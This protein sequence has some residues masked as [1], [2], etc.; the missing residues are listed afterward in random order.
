MSTTI[1]DEPFPP[2]RDPDVRPDP[3]KLRGYWGDPADR[4]ARPLWDPEAVEATPAEPQAE[5]W[6][7]ATVP[8]VETREEGA[9]ARQDPPQTQ[10]RDPSRWKEP[11]H[12]V[13]A[14]ARSSVLVE[15]QDAGSP[16]DHL[17]A[18][19]LSLVGGLV[20]SGL[21]LTYLLRPGTHRGGPSLTWGLA[22]DSL[23]VVIAMVFLGGIFLIMGSLVGRL[24]PGA[25]AWS[26][27]V[28]WIPLAFLTFKVAAL[29]RPELAARIVDLPMVA[30]FAGRLP[31]ISRQLLSLG[32]LQIVLVAAAL[33]G[34]FWGATSGAG[35]SPASGASRAGENAEDASLKPE[36][37]AHPS[38]TDRVVAA[39]PSDK[40]PA[41]RPARVADADL[42]DERRPVGNRG[43]W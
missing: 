29:L 3:A 33:L 20:A 10:R 37:G 26:A 12:E 41:A 28:A 35:P 13:P 5:A 25:W 17:L 19:L 7:A 1:D 22:P 23:K 32:G 15:A 18:I 24:A 30:Q 2:E 40:A 6:P 4:P 31:P 8:A 9:M 38:P 34:G 39:A 27:L 14:P 21:A 43:Y 36:Q 11:V 16:L 42:R